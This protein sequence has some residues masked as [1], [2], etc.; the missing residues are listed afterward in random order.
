[1]ESDAD[2]VRADA[3]PDGSVA[4]YEI[5]QGGL[6]ASCY[7]L[8][9]EVVRLFEKSRLLLR[10]LSARRRRDLFAVSVELQAGR[11]RVAFLDRQEAEESGLL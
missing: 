7:V 6:N 5:S 4:L 1:M 11:R 2:T 10:R 3:R 8:E 9:P